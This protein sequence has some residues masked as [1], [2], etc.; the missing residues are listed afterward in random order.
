MFGAGGKE[1]VFSRTVGEKPQYSMR[2]ARFRFIFNTR[3]GQEELYE[4]V[5]D[6]AEQVNVVRAQPV[7][8]ACYRQALAQWIRG[9]ERGAERKTATPGLPLDVAENLKAL[10]YLR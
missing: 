1:A 9:L 3:Y 8:A 4:L 6:P 7:M 2:D 10:G 5:R